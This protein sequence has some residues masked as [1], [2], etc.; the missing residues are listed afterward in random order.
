MDDAGQRAGDGAPWAPQESLKR[1]LLTIALIGG[2][3]LF[4]LS[5]VGGF[6]GITLEWLTGDDRWGRL[7]FSSLILTGAVVLPFCIA[8][9]WV[10]GPDGRVQPGKYLGVLALGLVAGWFLYGP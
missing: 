6:A 4:V 1:R 5:V 3:G 7:T 2:A 10:P 8:G 9:A